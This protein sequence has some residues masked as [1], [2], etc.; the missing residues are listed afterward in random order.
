M[1]AQLESEYVPNSHCIVCDTQ[2]SPENDSAEHAIPNAIGGRLKV[3]RFICCGCNSATGKTWDAALAA[4]LNPLSLLFQIV[5]ERGAT[6]AMR[7]TTTAGEN[8]T[9]LSD[10]SLT[11]ANPS[12][13][14]QQ[15]ER[16]LRVSFTARDRKEA[17]RILKG[18]KRKYHALD[19]GKMLAE[20]RSDPVFPEGMIHH[21]LEFGGEI[22]GRSIVKSTLAIAHYAGIK[23]ARG[24]A[25]C[26]LRDPTFPAPFGYYYERD[27]VVDRPP[28]TPFHCISVASNPETGLVLGY[29]EYFGIHRVVVCLARDF[30]GPALKST[31]AIDPRTGQKLDVDIRLDLGPHD[32]ARIY[33]YE[34]VPNDGVIAAFQSVVPEALKRNHRR[35]RDRSLSEAIE[36]GFANCGAKEGE[37]LT[38]EHIK[39]LSHLV[40]ERITPFLIR[41]APRPSLFEET[42]ED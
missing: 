4:Q 10:G 3:R 24:D 33:D 6:P 18:L 38:E 22:V 41:R 31:Y 26:Y 1:G 8:L 21:K 16:G 36:Y 17:N 9:I 19:I 37:I 2:L 13:G 11:P 28:A 7:V 5:R 40:A 12:F 34:T 23:L 39:M 20:A 14:I 32:L 42:E 35:S 15:T 30:R 25:L 27:L 29:A